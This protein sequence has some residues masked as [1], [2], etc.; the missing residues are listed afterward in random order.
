[1]KKIVYIENDGLNAIAICRDNYKGV[2]IQV[3][4]LLDQLVKSGLD[5]QLSNVRTNQV[6]HQVVVPLNQ[7]NNSK[8]QDSFKTRVQTAISDCR[9]VLTNIRNADKSIDG[10]LN[11]YHSQFKELNE[12]QVGS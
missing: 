8:T 4:R 5:N 7:N 3:V 1:M 11:D 12:G 6:V 9:E 2:V 10:L